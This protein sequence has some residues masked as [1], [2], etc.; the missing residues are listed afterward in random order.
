[1]REAPISTVNAEKRT[2]E[3]TWTSGAQV[4]RYDWMPRSPYLEELSLDPKHVRMERLCVRQGAAA[5]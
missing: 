5:R 4:Q 2:A 3:L 1:V